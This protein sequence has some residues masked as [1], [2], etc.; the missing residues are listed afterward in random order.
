M[1]DVPRSLPVS[2]ISVWTLYRY[3]RVGDQVAGLRVCHMPVIPT[4]SGAHSYRDSAPYLGEMVSPIPSYC[5]SWRTNGPPGSPGR[6]R[7][8]RRTWLSPRL[9]G[10][11]QR[12]WRESNTGKEDADL[13]PGLAEEKC[14]R[15]AT[16][17]ICWHA[18]VRPF[19]RRFGNSGPRRPGE[20][21]SR[22][23]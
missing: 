21:P 6:T 20:R 2:F 15:A 19:R 12:P 11:S 1:C 5:P 23:R 17:E 7:S 9:V 13:M 8:A 14:P 4:I 3:G 18:I 10:T 16:W 22:R